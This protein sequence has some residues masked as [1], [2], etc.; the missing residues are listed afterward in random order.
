MKLTHFA[1][2]PL[3]LAVIACS[4]AD[5]TTQAPQ[6]ALA[7]G[8]GTATQAVAG[9]SASPVAAPVTAATTS[10]LTMPAL[11]DGYKRFVAPPVDVPAGATNDWIQWVAGPMDQDYDVISLKG[12]QSKGGHHALMLSIGESND[13]GFTRLYTERD[14]LTSSSVGG[15]GAEGNVAIPEGVVFRL[16]KGRYLAIQSHYLN[17]S[18]RDIQGET[19]I[20]IQMTPRNEANTVAGHFASTT[21]SLSLPAKAQTS[22]DVYCDIKEDIPVLRMTNHMHY[23]GRSTFTEYTD[24]SGM[25]HMLKKD[26]VWSEDWALTPNYDNFP[27]SAPLIIPAG[28]KLHTQCTWNN[29]TDKALTFPEEMCVFATI[30]LGEREISC[31][32]NKFNVAGAAVPNAGAAGAPAAGAPAAGAAGAAGAAPVAGAAAPATGATG[33]CT[34]SADK[35][36]LEAPEFQDSQRTCGSMCFG[37]AETCATECLTKNTTLTP[38]CAACNG[39]QITCAMMH[40]VADCTGGFI[41]ASCKPCLETNCGEAYHACAGL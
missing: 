10:S 34:N 6:Q 8:N 29:E 31:I 33:A 40:C 23:A 38:E 20:D 25:T 21:V 9:T 27:V 22:L 3:A 32:E 26:D 13:P 2:L 39:A 15:I 5:S 11:E 37:S 14:Q 41:S 28:S 19:Y 36:L 16:K 35:A 30:I 18:E 17:T 4:S 7:A 24:P 1:K 12:A